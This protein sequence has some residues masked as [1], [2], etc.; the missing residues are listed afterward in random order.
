MTYLLKYVIIRYLTF[1]FRGDFMNE[2]TP[3][4]L[5]GLLHR[6]SKNGHPR[7]HTDE[8]SRSSGENFRGRGR[9]LSILFLE[10]G[11]SQKILAERL[12]IR[13]QSLSETVVK[14]CEEGFVRRV[15]SDH[16]KREILVFITDEGRVRAKEIKA[17]RE[18]FATEFFSVLSDSEKQ[19]LKD[20]LTKLEMNI[21]KEENI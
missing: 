10:D 3:Q 5:L 13:P 1:C 12:E 14:L 11:L 4:E 20:I 17:R 21:K 15:A 6:V 19:D 7:H 9:I 2:I 16:D 8:K 18:A